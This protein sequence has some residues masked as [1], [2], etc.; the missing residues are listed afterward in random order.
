MIRERVSENMLIPICR[1]NPALRQVLRSGLR[2]R[3]A[4]TLNRECS[5]TSDLQNQLSN[6]NVAGS[7][8]PLLTLGIPRETYNPWERR[9]ALTPDQVQA[10]LQKNSGRLAVT[11]Q[12]S[13]RR[14]FA[15]QDYHQAGA[16]IVAAD[17]DLDHC[18]V[19]LGV[20]R[21]HS[22]LPGKTYLFF[23]HTIK[24]QPE[25]M[26]LLREC[27]DKKVQ[28]I[29]YERITTAATGKR[30]V[31]FGRFAGIAGTMDSFHFLGRQLLHSENGASTPFLSFPSAILH[32]SLD[33]AKDRVRQLGERVHFEGI[34]L[35]EPLVIAVTGRGGCVHEGAM[36]ILQLLPHEVVPVSD[37]PAVLPAQSA[38]TSN[39]SSSSA[40]QYKIHVVPVGME[41]VFQ[42]CDDEFYDRRDFQQH[43]SEYRSLFAKRVAPYAH[44]IV[45]CAYWDARFPRLLTKRQLKRLWENGNHRYAT[46]FHIMMVRWS[47][48]LTLLHCNFSSSLDS[49]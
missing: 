45:N 6:E 34:A 14:I 19:I 15:D 31:S 1:L 12:S 8:R 47:P 35:H 11:V 41:D 37:L 44:A 2:G 7:A 9:V 33:E 10:L 16:T 4:W 25:N 39:S 18:N 48:F 29:D 26:A 5:T 40:L 24:G 28:L 22:V 49:G 27:L 20:K 43:P 38:E 30:L 17:C 23:S 32:D 42:R 36:E 21:P 13:A 46:R 3:G